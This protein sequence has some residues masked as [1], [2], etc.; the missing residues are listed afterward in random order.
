MARK[1]ST[2]QIAKL[3]DERINRLCGQRCSGVQISIMDI[4]KVFKV[5]N[6]A[7]V[8]NAEISDQALGDKIA[9]YVNTI[10]KN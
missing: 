6:Q 2:K 4:P 5:A 3:N 10:R 7:I 1:L 8:E 9:E